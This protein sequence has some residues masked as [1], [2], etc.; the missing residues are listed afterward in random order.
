MATSFQL[1][2]STANGGGELALLIESLDNPQAILGKKCQIKFFELDDTGAPDPLATFTAAIHQAS[3]TGAAPS[4]EF[5]GVTRTDTFAASLPGYQERKS[6]DGSTSLPYKPQWQTPHFTLRFNNPL[7]TAVPS[8]SFTILIN[9]EEGEVEKYTYQIGFEVTLDG[10]KIFSSIAAPSTVDC[11]HVLAS[12][13]VEAATLY[14]KDHQDLIDTRGIGTQYGSQLENHLNAS[15]Q[16][17]QVPTLNANIKKYKLEKTDCITYVLAALKLGHEKS[18]A[19]D[20]WK[21]IYAHYL[22]DSKRS[23]ISLAKGLQ[24]HGWLGIYYNRDTKNH[25]HNNEHAF[26]YTVAKGTKK[27]YYKLQVHGLVVDYGSSP[28]TEFTKLKG[29]PFGVINARG[30][31]HTALLMS[32]NVYEVHWNHGPDSPELYEA[33]RFEDW[34]ADDQWLS[35]IIHTPKGYW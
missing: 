5:K 26:S 10:K 9:G 14:M 23:G 19:L 27:T 7:G 12:N 3:T 17:A 29:I 20:D 34:T 15:G 2:P 4:F 8:T 32:G 24:D 18:N 31:F 11:V 1:T 33:T 22:K 13:C 16:S 30:G 25:S 21:K 28:T 35:G 6:A